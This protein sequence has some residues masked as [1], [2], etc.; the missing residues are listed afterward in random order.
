MNKVFI[1]TR[2]SAAK[3]WISANAEQYGLSNAEEMFDMTHLSD[4]VLMGISE[5]DVV[6][7]VLP[8][9]LVAAVCAKGAKFFNLDLTV[10]AEAR[11]RELTVQDMDRYGARL[12]PYYVK[13]LDG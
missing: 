5:E 7:G 2:H 12:T 13:A 11:G 8:L 10:P 9:S 1:V 6:V 3:D 4:E